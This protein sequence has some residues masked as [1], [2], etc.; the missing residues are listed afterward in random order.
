MR[1]SHGVGWRQEYWSGL[2]FP[3]PGD[4]SHPG[5]EPGSPELQEILSWLSYRGI[6]CLQGWVANYTENL[7]L[8]HADPCSNLLRSSLWPSGLPFMSCS[9]DFASFSLW[10]ALADTQR[11]REW[12]SAIYSCGF[13]PEALSTSSLCPAW[14]VTALP[15]RL[16]HCAASLAP[17][18]LPLLLPRL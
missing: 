7:L 8:G 12:T 9:L 11:D 4:L 13:L 10:G 5:I 17:L 14:E 15:D 6:P 2:P 1:F 18:F 16:L 3:S